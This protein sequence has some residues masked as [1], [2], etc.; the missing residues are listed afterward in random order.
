MHRILLVEDNP[1]LRVLLQDA[2][3]AA[4]YA[5]LAVPEG[6]AALEAQQ[7]AAADLIVT[8]LFMPGMEGIETIA[9]LRRQYPARIKIIAISGGSRLRGEGADHLAVAREIGAD[10]AL[11]KPFKPEQLVE[12]VRQVLG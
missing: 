12:A 9:E 4:G 2:L 7:R 6:G 8:D 3:E 5:V 1:D 11:K 10:G